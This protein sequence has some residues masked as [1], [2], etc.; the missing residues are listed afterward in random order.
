MSEIVR[1]KKDSKLNQE[2]TR[3][4]IEKDNQLQEVAARGGSVSTLPVSDVLKAE[5][6]ANVEKLTKSYGKGREKVEV[7]LS[8]GAQF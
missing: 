1:D 4:L 2:A 5:Q 7:D 6:R 8:H 3:H